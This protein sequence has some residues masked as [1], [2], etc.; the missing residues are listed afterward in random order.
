MMEE[1]LRAGMT[2]DVDRW[3][4]TL[5]NESKMSLQEILWLSRD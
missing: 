3:D 5:V 1:I 2:V 4:R